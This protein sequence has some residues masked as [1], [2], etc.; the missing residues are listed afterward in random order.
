MVA[1]M[2]VGGFRAPESQV[3]DNGCRLDVLSRHL[4]SRELVALVS[5]CRY[6]VLPYKDA[7]QSGVALTAYGLGK[8]VVATD[9]GGLRD[10][11]A[12]RL[13]GRLVPAGD[14]A[15]L[16]RAI[17]DLCD[18]PSELA[19]LEAGV[20]GSISSTLS[21]ERFAG[22]VCEVYREAVLGGAKGGRSCPA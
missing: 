17:V 3:L 2:P 21:W 22:E 4:T 16:A 9:V 1:G 7:S 15:H 11:V 19:R 20:R 13:T 18:D 8:C 5:G 6:L 10:Y 12:D 14:P